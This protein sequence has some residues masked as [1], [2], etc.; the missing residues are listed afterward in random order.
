M[1]KYIIEYEDDVTSNRGKTEVFADSPR[2]AEKKFYFGRYSVGAFC[3]V[4]NLFNRR[5]VRSVYT[6]TGLPDESGEVETEEYE[7]VPTYYYPPRII[8]LC[9]SFGF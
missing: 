1:I 5:N 8:Y 6:F 7:N 3:E 2:E 9:L 4:Y